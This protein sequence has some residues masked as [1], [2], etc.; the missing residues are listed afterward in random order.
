MTTSLLDIE[1]LPPLFRELIALVGE[2]SA[3]ALVSAR[4]GLRVYIPHDG[5]LQRQPENWLVELL[6][7]ETA[8]KLGKHYGHTWLKLP[9]LDSIQR[10]ARHKAIIAA[11]AQGESTATLAIRFGYT[12]RHIERIIASSKH[13]KATVSFVQ[14][15]LCG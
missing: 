12:E 11:Y 3:L 14:L 10:E 9:K 6:G 8:L 2:P 1:D 4:P 15:P 7:I 13:A 5:W